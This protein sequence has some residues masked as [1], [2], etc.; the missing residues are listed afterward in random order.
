MGNADFAAWVRSEGRHSLIARLVNEG[1]PITWGPPHMI[2]DTYHTYSHVC[3]AT[4]VQRLAP[5]TSPLHLRPSSVHLP[6]VRANPNPNPTQ[7]RVAQEE[8]EGAKLS[9]TQT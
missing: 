5:A 3:A 4:K 2:K 8:A 9:L 6:C 7:V 1:D